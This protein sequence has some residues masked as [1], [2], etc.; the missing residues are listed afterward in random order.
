L[1]T[2]NNFVGSKEYDIKKKNV[3]NLFK[4]VSIMDKF[5]FLNVD[6]F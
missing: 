6:N 5:D 1:P 3:S 2:L 4:L